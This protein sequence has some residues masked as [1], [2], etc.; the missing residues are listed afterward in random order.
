MLFKFESLLILSLV[1]ISN[2][3]LHH[4]LFSVIHASLRYYLTLWICKFNVFSNHFQGLICGTCTCVIS[5][6]QQL[7]MTGMIHTDSEDEPLVVR[8]CPIC[9]TKLTATQAILSLLCI[10]KS[11]KK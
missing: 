4:V 11:D 6:T 8:P 3:C 1:L 9:R 7:T 2:Q 5:T 10:I